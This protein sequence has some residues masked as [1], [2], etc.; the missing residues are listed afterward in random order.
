MKKIVLSPNPYRDRGLVLTNRARELLERDGRETVIAPVFV[1]VPGDSNMVPLRRAAEDAELIISFGGD[2]TFLHVARQIL[3]MRIPLLG[4]NVGTKGFMAGLEPEDIELV[5]RAAAGDFRES[6][7]MMLDIELHRAD[8]EVIRD[9]ALNDAVVKSDVN[10]INLAVRADGTE[11]TNFAGDGVIIA[12]PTGSTAYSMS[13]GGPIVEPEAANIIITPICAHIMAAKSFVLAPERTV[14][15]TPERLRGRR[16]ALSVD[17]SEG[18]QLSS[19][20]EVRARWSG[21]T[22]IMADM[23]VRSFYDTALNKLTQS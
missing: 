8:G 12:T 14:T 1:D 5:R 9:C 15:V 16:A 19:G 20:D 23:Q 21:N 6:L 2:G 22:V 13:A 3:G 17:G 11:I 10:C 7:R 4:V 18:I